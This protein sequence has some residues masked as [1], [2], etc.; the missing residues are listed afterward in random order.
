MTI[1]FQ[2]QQAA[3]QQQTRSIV[4]NYH[5]VSITYLKSC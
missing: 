2:S 3:V 1:H 4:Y 5:V